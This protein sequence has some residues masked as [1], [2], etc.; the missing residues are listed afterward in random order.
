MF[1]NTFDSLSIT[2]YVNRWTPLY[3][4]LRQDSFDMHQNQSTFHIDASCQYNKSYCCC[5]ELKHG[6]LSYCYRTIND[7]Y[8]MD[9]Q[10]SVR[11]LHAI[12]QSWSF[13]FNTTVV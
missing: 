13:A 4:S 11:A 2:I 7:N 8:N 5:C 6:Y 1:L 3:G 12:N 9:E 10:R